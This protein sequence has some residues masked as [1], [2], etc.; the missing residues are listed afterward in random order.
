MTTRFSFLVHGTVQG[1]F[2]RY[3]PPHLLLPLPPPPILS[4]SHTTNTLS[5]RFTKDAATERNLTGW[6]RNTPNSKVEGEVQGPRAKVMDFLKE[7]DKGP[8]G[9]HVI[10]V[11]TSEIEVVGGEE[12]F[13]VRR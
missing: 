10:R 6:V 12:G 9:A 5:S 4:L 8:R 2:F 11:D 13:E 3:L 1:V 7:V